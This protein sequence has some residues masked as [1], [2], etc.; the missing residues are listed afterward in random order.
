MQDIM[1]D[2]VNKIEEAQ[3]AEKNQG[4]NFGMPKLD[5]FMQVWGSKLILIAARPGMGKSALAWSIA[6]KLGYEREA[7][8]FLSI[9]MDKEQYADRALSVEADINAMNFYTRGSLNNKKLNDLNMAANNLS[10]LPITINDSES[11]IED[12]K[13]RGRKFK[14]MGKKLLVIDQLSQIAYPKNLKPVIGIGRNCT[15]IKQL[16]KELRI[17]IILLCQL[18]RDLE[19]RNN[20]RPILS[21]LAETGRAEQDS[22]IILFIYRPGVYDEKIDKSQTE[23]ILAKNRQGDCGTEKQVYFNKSRGMFQLTI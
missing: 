21:D 18:N 16:G 5:N 10:N 22:D 20:K 15:A 13:R 2:A 1:V 14:K 8:G 23:I 9:E 3:T 4:L 7:V 17:P 11:D 19:K 6:L 12:V